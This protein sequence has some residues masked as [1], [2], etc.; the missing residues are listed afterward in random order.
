MDKMFNILFK[1]ICSSLCLVALLS[2]FGDTVNGQDLDQQYEAALYSLGAVPVSKLERKYWH[3]QSGQAAY[4]KNQRVDV[5]GWLSPYWAQ[6]DFFLNKEE[7]KRFGLPKPPLTF[8]SYVALLDVTTY[9]ETRNKK[10]YAVMA[11]ALEN[12]LSYD[13]QIPDTE[14]IRRVFAAG[15]GLETRALK[16]LK[17]RIQYRE[18][19]QL[20]RDRPDPRLPEIFPMPQPEQSE[21]IA[22]LR[23]VSETQPE[24]GWKALRLL[25][26]M[27][28][29]AYWI[30]FRDLLIHISPK[31]E[32]WSNRVQMYR[33][34]VDIGDVS[35]LEAL[36][37]A[38]GE[39]QVTEVRE[40]I[41]DALSTKGLWYQPMI[42]KVIQ[43]AQGGGNAHEAVT[44][45][46]M[47][48]QWKR[49]LRVFLVWAAEY[50]QCDEQTRT[51]I[52][53]VLTRLRQD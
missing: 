29:D 47:V 31:S 23:E 11:F 45:S 19:M 5:N 38:I 46:R 43:L 27:D 18:A 13:I 33:A 1:I 30:P 12:M 9:R 50:P 24:T 4:L 3:D 16:L 21:Y 36:N 2:A 40:S 42:E 26:R 35:S 53:R 34:I 51:K 17:G 8:E 28:H 25:Y 10:L 49:S 41:L 15:I 14:A 39:D 6:S 37:R 32:D 7:K 44:P 20:Y 22:F 52:K 48:D